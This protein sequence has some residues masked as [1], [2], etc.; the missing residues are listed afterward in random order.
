MSLP[1]KSV[2]QHNFPSQS[3]NKPFGSAPGKTDNTK[4]EPLK[5]WGCGEEHLLRDF[6]HRKQDNRRVYNIQEAT[7]VNDVARS[8]PQIYAALDN[9]QVDHQASVV[10]MEGMISNH[11]VSILIDPGSNLSYVSPQTVEKCKLQQVKHAKSWLVQLATGTK[12]KVTEVIPACQFIMNG[13][14]TQETLNMLPLGSYDLLI[15]MDWLASHKT[16]LDCYN[17]TLECEDEEGRKITLQGIQNP[18]LSE[19]N[20]IPSSEEV[21]QK[22]MSFVC[23]TSV[24][25]C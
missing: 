15:G 16:K 14:P 4:R 12:R 13:L 25:L 1:T 6:P 17:K 11:L 9:R 19:T 24:E 7:T 5:C 10:E 8:M 23:N 21:L 20:I 22:R 2:Y 18:C 3:G